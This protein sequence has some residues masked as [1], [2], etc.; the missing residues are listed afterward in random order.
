MIDSIR[1]QPLCLNYFFIVPNPKLIINKIKAAAKLP[2]ILF[3]P[4]EIKPVY[5]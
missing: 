2:E 4:S 3:C 5:D 1:E